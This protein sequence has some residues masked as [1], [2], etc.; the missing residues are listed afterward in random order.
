MTLIVVPL[1]GLDFRN[2][3]RSF[4]MGASSG[5]SGEESSKFASA[6]KADGAIRLSRAAEIP[7]FVAC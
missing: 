2:S 7:S 1:Y 5:T 4:V 3:M 6:A